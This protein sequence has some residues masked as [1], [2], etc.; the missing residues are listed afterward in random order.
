[1][2][3]IDMSEETLLREI[4]NRYPEAIFHERPKSHMAKKRI[5]RWVLYNRAA[6]RFVNDIF[7][8]V[9]T[10]KEDLSWV[11]KFLEIPANT[12]RQKLPPDIVEA[13]RSFIEDY[14]AWR[15]SRRIG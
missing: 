2:V 9:N 5:F 11:L 14:K 13:R 8:Y 15:A 4:H 10:K 12:S 6:G 3:A 7:P 1:M